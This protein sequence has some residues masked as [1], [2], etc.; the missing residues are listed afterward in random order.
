MSV[1]DLHLSDSDSFS[2][3]KFLAKAMKEAPELEACVVGPI[4]FPSFRN[5][6]LLK[7]LS[8][9]LSAV[10]FSSQLEAEIKIL[11]AITN[12]DASEV[13]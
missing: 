1:I 6:I 2:F 11:K 7:C 13:L 5:N 8:P 9:R 3:Y 12:I 4:F 10:E